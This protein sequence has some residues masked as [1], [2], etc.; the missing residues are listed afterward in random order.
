M[1][2]RAS[3]RG[4][5]RARRTTQSTTRRSRSARKQPENN[6]K[7][8]RKQPEKDDS[9]QKLA[10][11]VLALLRRNPSASRREIAA[12]LGIT[13]STVRYRLDKLRKAGK[14]ERVGPDKGGHW[15]V[16]GDSASDP[17]P[18]PNP[19]KPPVTAVGDL[20]IRTQ[21]RV[22]GHF[23]RRLGYRYLCNW[24]ECPEQEKAAYRG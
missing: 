23:R 10:D 7:T 3:L 16:L 1:S 18:E 14:I 24:R 11:R 6:Q 5:W 20:E 22:I 17:A 15:K 8:T 4:I 12:T 2:A 9:N 13:E 19:R 21:R